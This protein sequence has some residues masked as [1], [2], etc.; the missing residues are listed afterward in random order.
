VTCKQIVG[1]GAAAEYR[2]SE[3]LPPP[4]EAGL[5]RTRWY[6]ADRSGVQ[7]RRALRRVIVHLP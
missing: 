7:Q 4:L 5:L 3:P 6:S 2:P 1:R